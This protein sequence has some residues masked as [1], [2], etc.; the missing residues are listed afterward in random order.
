MS[1]SSNPLKGQDLY[2][3]LLSYTFEHKIVF[4][5]SILAMAAFAITD[6]AFAALMK[7]LLDGSFV[8]KDP[9]IIKYFPIVLVGLF[10]IIFGSQF[11]LNLYL[12]KSKIVV[13]KG[14]VDII[15]TGLERKDK[16]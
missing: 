14:T 6:T 1:Q 16:P 13:K 5:F 11:W 7:P 8:E 12:I 3:R 9:D 4:F 10:L 2:R 15:A